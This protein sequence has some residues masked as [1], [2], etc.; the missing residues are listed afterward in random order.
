MILH[1]AV[2]ENR[3]INESVI[4][5]TEEFIDK[6]L[7]ATDLIAD[8]YINTH[9]AFSS[10]VTMTVNNG[11]MMANVDG[12]FALSQAE[13]IDSILIQVRQ[14]GDSTIILSSF[15]MFGEM[16]D[17]GDYDADLYFKVI[18]VVP[19]CTLKCF[20]SDSKFKS[21][22]TAKLPPITLYE[23]PVA[24][25]YEI[26]TGVTVLYNYNGSAIEFWFEGVEYDGETEYSWT[27]SSNGESY[28][29][30]SGTDHWTQVQSF[31]N[32][33]LFSYIS[34][35][36]P[37]KVSIV[38]DKDAV[39]VSNATPTVKFTAECTYES[40]EDRTDPENPRNTGRFTLSV[41]RDGKLVE[42]NPEDTFEYT[43]Q[44][45]TESG[46]GKG[47]GKGGGGVEPPVYLSGS[48]N[49]ITELVIVD[50][51]VQYNNGE[52]FEKLSA[53]AEK[54]SAAI[55]NGGIEMVR[56]LAADIHRNS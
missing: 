7:A 41:Y 3:V 17:T 21:L 27:I 10:R 36:Y 45:G 23:Q 28:D 22:R 50:D 52:A 9:K 20:I 53:G 1:D 35:G 43:I 30:N 33:T 47:G 6:L 37:I 32:E 12:R 16:M 15:T 40:Y 55:G 31:E 48:I 49:G 4:D 46:G 19:N 18:N 56:Y 11:Y 54:V 24:P 51:D 2:I 34:E 5:S 14:S 39:I 42:C 8:V 26:D 44:I 25:G 38:D 13:T 29:D